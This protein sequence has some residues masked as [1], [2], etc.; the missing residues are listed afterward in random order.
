MPRRI[1]VALAIAGEIA[2]GFFVT[3]ALVATGILVWTVLH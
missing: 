2:K 1:L 3:L